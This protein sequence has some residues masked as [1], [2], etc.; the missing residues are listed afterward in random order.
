MFIRELKAR[1]PGIFAWEIKDRLVSEEICDKFNVPSVSSI[2][3]ILRNKMSPK[4]PGS[5]E[6]DDAGPS[7]SSTSST[8]SIGNKQL[9]LYK[10]ESECDC[11]PRCEISSSQCGTKARTAGLH[12]QVPAI[13]G[14][15]QAHWL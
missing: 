6:S 2:S 14:G 9:G 5:P 11:E 1:D 12:H 3:R 13:S 15:D 4:A 10:S 7:A 8:S